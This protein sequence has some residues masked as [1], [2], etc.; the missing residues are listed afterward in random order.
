VLIAG[1]KENEE[2]TRTSL[3]H[4][5]R[6]AAEATA[7]RAE[8]FPAWARNP[9]ELQQLA[10]ATA[11]IFGWS[12][13]Q[14]P[15]VNYYGDVNTV[16]VCDEKRRQQLI[17]QRQRLLEQEATQASG[18]ETEAAAPVA[19]PAPETQPG[20]NVGAGNSTVAQ[21]PSPATP[22]DAVSQH[23][24][25]IRTAATW[26]PSDPEHHYGSFA[27]HPEEY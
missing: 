6:R 11:R 12:T 2:A 1:L 23:M 22:Q 16:V 9:Q 25:S 18:R 4:A 20:A 7:V 24:E 8:V 5:A 13:D 15:S 10:S 21:D 26:K 17:E 3:S 19:L 27:P 14:R